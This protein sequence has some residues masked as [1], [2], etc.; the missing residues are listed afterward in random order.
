MTNYKCEETSS[1]CENFQAAI[2]LHCNHRLCV[3]HMIEHNKIAF[4]DV[5]NLSHLTEETLQQIKDKG[6]KSRIACD[7]QLTTLGE[8]RI[9]E[10]EKIEQTCKNE[11]Q[12]IRVQ[13]EA[14]ENFHRRLSEQLERDARQPL[15]QALKQQSVNTEVLDFIRQTTEKIRKESIQLKWEFSPPSSDITEYPLDVPQVSDP[16]QIIKSTEDQQIT[17]ENSLSASSTN[18]LVILRKGH[19]FLELVKIF[20]NISSINQSRMDVDNYIR[21]S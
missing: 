8:W 14:L 1:I 2:C 20:L 13:E 6:E 19:A 7:D 5:E 9:K 11:L 18:N 12:C 16:M 21:V 17:N 3:R 15:E 4:N 10:L